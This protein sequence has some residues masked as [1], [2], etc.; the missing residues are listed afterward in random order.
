MRRPGRRWAAAPALALV[1]TASAA[2]CG[3]GTPASTPTTTTVTPTTTTV[4]P[5][6]SLRQMLLTAAD[7][8]VGWAPLNDSGGPSKLTGCSFHKLVNGVLAKSSAAFGAPSGF[9]EWREELD[10]VGSGAAQG[11]LTRAI[12]TLDGCHSLQLP[13]SNG[14][15]TNLTLTPVSVPT[16]GN[17]SGAWSLTGQI[18]GTGFTFYVMLARFGSIGGTFFYGVVGSGGESQFQTLAEKAGVRV[19]SVQGSPTGPTGGTGVT[20]GTGATGNTGVSGI[21]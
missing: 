21:S 10:D 18:Q 2:A 20:G 19:E 13:G 11:V 14:Q 4:V 12:A 7:F 8:P 9:P 16:V 5:A 1:V 15:V 3:S 6:A 17:Q